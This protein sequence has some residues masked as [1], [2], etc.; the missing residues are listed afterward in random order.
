MNKYIVWIGVFL[1]G[2]GLFVS[3]L[4]WGRADAQTNLPT[5]MMREVAGDM[6][7]NYADSSMMQEGMGDM[8]DDQNGCGMMANHA[9]GMMGN[10]NGCGMMVDDANGMMGGMMG[11]GMGGHHAAD[12]AEE[13]LSLE[14][15]TTA[16]TDYLATLDNST[17][18]LGAIMLFDNHAYAQIADTTAGRGAF[19]VLV[20]YTTG[21]VY[22]EH[23]PTR[24][25]N[26]EYGMLSNAPQAEM[27]MGGMM[28]GMMGG[29][30]PGATVQ[31]TAEQAVEIAQEYLAAYQAG[32]TVDTSVTTFPGYYTL[33]TLQD[34]VVVGVMSVNAYSG[35][36]FP[37]HWH[38]TLLEMSTN[39]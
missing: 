24:M 3:G 16:L 2:V 33:H 8:M 18:G 39:R 10:Q 5:D 6:M 32:Q 20:D 19:E 27:V 4:L 14:A 17:L 11:Q 37:H 31:V 26:T 12:P 30:A 15:V 35:Q 34:G 28:R 7:G 25:W 9:D 21:A 1:I 22:P 38:G 13:P 36:V 29:Y 23:G